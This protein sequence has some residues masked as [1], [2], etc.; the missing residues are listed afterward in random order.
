[1]RRI[2]IT[3]T[4]E[5][6]LQIISNPGYGADVIF[7]NGYDLAE[8]YPP[9]P[10]RSFHSSFTLACEEAPTWG[11]ITAIESHWAVTDL[12]PLRGEWCRGGASPIQALDAWRQAVGSYKGRQAA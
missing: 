2:D 4:N 9:F 7:A 5:E 8:A 6:L 3:F 10:G 12:K 11:A 1:M